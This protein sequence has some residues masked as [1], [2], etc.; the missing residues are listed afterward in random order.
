MMKIPLLIGLCA[1]LCTGAALADPGEL[2]RMQRAI[3][4]R[5]DSGQFMGS[6]LIA[7]NGQVLLS[8][9]Y[10][11]AS[12]TQKIANQ[13][14]T[15][16]RIGSETKQI[17]AASIL[18]L[19]ERGKLKLDDPIRKYMPEAPEEWSE[20][21]F[22]HLLNNSSGIP[23][24]TSLPSYRATQGIA[25]T[26]RQL[27]ERFRDRRL[28]FRPGTSFNY[29]NSGYILLG[30][31]IER[32]S[33]EP[34]GRFV[35]QSLFRPLKMWSSGYDPDVLRTPRLAQGHV[36]GP[37]G[38]SAAR[39][40]DPSVPYSS[41]GIYSTSGDLLK[42]VSALY[43]GKVLQ[44]GDLQEMLT[45]YK[46]H[47]GLGVTIEPGAGGGEVYSSGGGIDGFNTRVVYLP[48]SKLALIVLSNVGGESADE[49]VSDLRKVAD[50][51]PVTLASDRVPVTLASEM[52]D[53]T[54]GYYWSEEATLLSVTRKNDHLQMVGAGGTRDLYPASRRDFF[55]Q[56]ENVEM[57]FAEDD[58]GRIDSLV[59]H[60]KDRVVH[61]D[62]IA[63]G[64][65]RDLCDMRARKLKKRSVATPGSEDALRNLI[66][67]I[68]AGNP[69]YSRLGPAVGDM[70]RRELPRQ[71]ALL[72]RM[73]IIK[74]I[75]FAGVAS[76]SAADVYMVS[77]ERGSLQA[78]ISLGPD[79]RVW[80]Q[81]IR[82]WQGMPAD[83]DARLPQSRRE[84][85]WT[86]STP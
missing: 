25:V 7:R 84:A 81:E 71:Q 10:G 50:G 65:A 32:I 40:I 8:K 24:L 12:T 86:A 22:R 15:R 69:D 67:Q 47:Y 72:E 14:D 1:V 2:V 36:M 46:N 16:F 77:F 58:Q 26:P 54:T 30:Y 37:E 41:G 3:E 82:P 45:P 75:D 52:L 13:P 9:A 18:L 74:H 43:G 66:E 85:A 51:E 6:V 57:S 27:V 38:L 48:H 80:S 35:Q 64:E 49:L 19:V 59:I 79:G 76:S 61:A 39:F 28:D 83:L 63:P 31:L 17:T 11:L 60:L 34:Y 53:R 21:T 4:L 68:V 70:T 5:A 29:S 20:I 62:R 33:G 55:A 56:T 42:W 73:G 44:P 23:N 78:R